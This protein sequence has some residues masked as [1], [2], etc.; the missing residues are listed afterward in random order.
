MGVPVLPSKLSIYDLFH[1]REQYLVP[2]FQRGY[3][4]TLEKQISQLWEHVVEKLEELDEHH[5]NAKKVG[6]EKLRSIK[7]HFLGAIVVG[8][9]AHFDPLV[10]PSREVVDGQQRL[11]TLQLLLFALRDALKASGV[12]AGL[13]EDLKLLTHNG[14]NLRQ[15]SDHLK[16]M[17]TNVGREDMRALYELGDMELVCKR[18]PLRDQSGERL[19]R[20]A[21]VR[22]YLFFYAMATY[23]LRGRRFDDPAEEADTSDDAET[24]AE[25]VIR[26]VDR[27]QVLKIPPS[28]TKATVEPAARLMESLQSSFQIVRLQLESEDD[29]QVIFETLNALGAPLTPSDLIRNYLFLRAAKNNENVDELYDNHWKRFDEELDNI[30]KPRG[31]RYWRQ[32]ETQGRLTN[33]RLDLF[34]Y[35]YVGLRKL[36]NLKVSHV[37]E[38]FKVWWES[39]S[40]STGAELSRIDHLA[41]HFRTILTPGYDSEFDVFCRR[42][43]ILDTSTTTP[44]LFHLLESLE[45]ND[46]DF[47]AMLKDIE[48]YVVRRFVCGLTTKGYNRV[49]LDQLLVKMKE[50]GELSSSWLRAQLKA[51]E[52]DSQKWP[53]DAEFEAS[54]VYGELYKGRSS[55]KVRALLEGLESGLRTSKQE[56]QPK[57]DTLSIEHVMPQSWKADDWPLIPNTQAAREK[58]LRLL[59]SIGNLTLVTPGFNSSLSNEAFSIKR[60]EIAGNSSLI[61]NAYFQQFSDT[62]S[63][64]EDAI[65]ARAKALLPTALVAWPR[66]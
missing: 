3:V 26:S 2:L 15:K 1:P 40:R 10:V 52:G 14:G 55:R 36:E 38:E 13:E 9:P 32:L 46:P 17:P 11:T 51:L 33:T 64:D 7:K 29:S 50:K 20:P 35:H 44:L 31:P 41:S 16:V 22:A 60:P 19:V 61:L 62:F 56:F 58:R 48:S 66:P 57:L 23:L 21:T 4:W 6:A 8:P 65:V 18:F 39:G 53:T 54:W 42:L 12:D 30:Q 24:I 59:H 28:P 63:W 5:R 37:F 43:K 27:D 45:P 25:A 47:L 49:F 34:F